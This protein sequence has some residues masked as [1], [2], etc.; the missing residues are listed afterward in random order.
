MADFCSA[1]VAGFYSAVDNPSGVTGRH[2]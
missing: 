1:P 2:G